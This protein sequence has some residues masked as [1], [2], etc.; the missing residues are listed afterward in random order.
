MATILKQERKNGI[1]FRIQVLVRE[2]GSGKRVTKAVTYEPPKGLTAHEMY[3]EAQ[4]FAFQ[5]E[6]DCKKSAE[7]PS[8]VK[9]N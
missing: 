7:N 5:F 1:N 3:R 2:V 6:D 4:K 8:Q 9:I